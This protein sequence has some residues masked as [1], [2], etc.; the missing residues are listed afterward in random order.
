MDDNVIKTEEA[1]VQ[2]YDEYTNKTRAFY[3]V[4]ILVKTRQY[5]AGIE[6]YDIGYIYKFHTE[7]LTEPDD[8]I[9]YRKV[10]HPFYKE[11]P[12]SRQGEI[13]KKNKMTQA[14]VEFLLMPDEALAE[15]IG[16]TTP[17]RYRMDIMH[18]LAKMW[19]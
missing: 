16:M 5:D 11:D 7:E 8:I 2:F 1:V 9:H 3:E 14:M 19:D 13:V 6:Y 18:S 12:Q 4:R 15:E 17:Q 10:I